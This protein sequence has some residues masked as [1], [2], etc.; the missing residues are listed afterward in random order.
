MPSPSI[1]EEML[2]VNNELNSIAHKT[3]S[4]L[5]TAQGRGRFIV[6]GRSVAERLRIVSVLLYRLC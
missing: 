2:F 5:F 1:E 4:L 3:N 6:M